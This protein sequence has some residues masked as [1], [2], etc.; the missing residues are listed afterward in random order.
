[1]KKVNIAIDGFSACGKS[2]TAKAMARELG[3][4]YVDSG[5]MYRAVTLYFLDHNITLTNPREVQKALDNIKITFHVNPKTGETETF[6]NVL[7][8]EEEIR[9]MRVTEHVSQ[10]SALSPVRKAMVSQ[11]QKFGK[12]KG[13]VMDGRDIGTVVF[14]DAALKI[15]MIADMNIRVERRQK[16]LFEKN[17]LVDFEEVKANLARR[18][19]IDSTRE[20][21]P[22]KQA[23][24][25]LIIDT[26]YLT[27]DE[28]I[29]EGLNLATSRI[30]EQN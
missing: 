12:K 14:P 17:Q 24:D 19:A 11:Q 7:R 25:A 4:L 20:D 23:D 27:L 6:L 16:E 18:D 28:Q 30:L 8:V 10:V 2:T 21:S 13:V 9:T 26:T 1:M 15:F 3:Y 5:A 29:E 22:L